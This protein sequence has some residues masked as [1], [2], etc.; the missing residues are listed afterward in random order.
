MS[1]NVYLNIKGKFIGIIG[2]DS[3]KGSLESL[4]EKIDYI[5]GVEL[6]LSPYKTMKPI[7]IVTLSHPRYILFTSH[8]FYDE[9]VLMGAL[10]DSRFLQIL[11]DK[12]ILIRK[13][14]HD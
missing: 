1:S 4:L 13:I 11:S 10:Q 6:H 5:E 9:D 3:I 12:G 7:L 8:S 2:Y 14:I